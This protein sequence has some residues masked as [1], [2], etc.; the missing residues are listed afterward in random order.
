MPIGFWGL[1]FRIV[2]CLVIQNYDKTLKRAAK[3]SKVKE[4]ELVPL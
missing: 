2:S 1:G 3:A 4:P